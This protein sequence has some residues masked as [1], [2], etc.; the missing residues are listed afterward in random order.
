LEE[1]PRAWRRENGSYPPAR[2]DH[3]YS[4][5]ETSSADRPQG[6]NFAPHGKDRALQR[7]SG[8][9]RGEADSAVA[10][11]LGLDAFAERRLRSAKQGFLSKLIIRRRLLRLATSCGSNHQGKGYVLFPV[12]EKP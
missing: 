11:S 7:R 2:G 8:R 12:D 3:R 5:T 9:V 6:P 4:L 10:R 1:R